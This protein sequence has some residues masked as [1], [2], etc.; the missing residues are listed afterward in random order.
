MRKLITYAAVATASLVGAMLIAAAP[1]WSAD[2]GG[3]VTRAEAEAM[4]P[5]S[6]WTAVYGSVSVGTGALTSDA[7]PIGIEGTA[8]GARVGADVQISRVLFGV[9][10]NYQWDHVSMFGGSVSPKEWLV[11]ARAGVL[12]TDHA[13]VY[14]LVGSNKLRISGMDTRGLATGGG[15][16]VAMTKN[17][18]RGLEYQRTTYDDLPTFHEQVISARLIF[19]IPA[20]G[21][22]R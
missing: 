6:P 13:L 11:A 3:P 19:A 15:L 12:V 2:K 20:Y 1:T 17:W 10:T 5:Q 16:E 21:L 4:F 8:F 22:F 18:R 7:I 9:Y 14:G